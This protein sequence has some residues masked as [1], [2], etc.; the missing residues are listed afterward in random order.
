M[1]INTEKEKNFIITSYYHQHHL[2]L[3]LACP[4]HREGLPPASTYG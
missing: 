4:N 1:N 2:L 3:I